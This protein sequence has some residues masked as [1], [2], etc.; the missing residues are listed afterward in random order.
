MKRVLLI[1]AA[2]ASPCSAQLVNPPAVNLSTYATKAEV[3]A[4][5]ATA[6]SACQPM[7]AIPPSETIGGAAG[8]GSNCRLVNSIQPRISRFVAFTT[9]AD[10]TAVVT[11][12]SMGSA[13]PGVTI[14]ENIASNAT[15]VPKCYPVNG[16]LTA[17]GVTVKCYITQS[18]LGLGLIPF[19]TAT[20]GVTGTVLTLPGS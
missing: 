2:L 6:A 13:P 14:Q 1:A 8:S 7:A 16:T 17:T 20:A 11:W 3:S 18:I 19:T 9:G 4:V 5:Q 15:N 10:G 12:Q